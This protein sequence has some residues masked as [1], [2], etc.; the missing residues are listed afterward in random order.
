MKYISMQ[1]AVQHCVLRAVD[2]RFVLYKRCAGS[3]GSVREVYSQGVLVT[4]STVL[5]NMTQMEVLCP[6]GL[7]GHV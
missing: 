7:V 4:A 1:C 3:G 2:H 6:R 5:K